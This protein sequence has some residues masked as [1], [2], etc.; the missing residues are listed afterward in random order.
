MH[1]SS[2][3][4]ITAMALIFVSLMVGFDTLDQYLQRYQ[5]KEAT[6]IIMQEM[7]KECQAIKIS[8]GLN[9]TFS[10]TSLALNQVLGQT[11]HVLSQESYLELVSR[12][13]VSAQN[14][15]KI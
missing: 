15:N 5:S 3:H 11:P 6:K 2:L 4:S 10:Q 14:K 9:D 7:V 13:L 1:S 12:C 8:Q